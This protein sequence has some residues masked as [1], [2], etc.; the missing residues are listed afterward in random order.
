MRRIKRI[1]SLLAIGPWLL[2]PDASVLAQSV[3]PLMNF[4]GQ[5][6]AVDGSPLTTGD[7][8]LTFQIFDASEG[9][10]LIW[11]PQVLDG[12]GGAGHGP[13]IPVVQGYFNVM[14]GPVD[15]AAR[16]LT[17]A[18]LG[19]TRFL[20][21]KVGTNSPIS[22]RQQILSAPYALNTANAA[23][24]ANV[25]AGGVSTFA[26][27]DGAVTTAKLENGAVTAAKLDPAIG[28]WTRSGNDVFRSLGN[29]GIGTTTPSSPLHVRGGIDTEIAIES[30][31]AAGRRWTLQSSAAVRGHRFEIIDRSAEQNRFTILTNGNVGIG[32]TT[33][34]FPLHIASDQPVMLLHDTGP[35]STQA[36]YIG[37]RNNSFTETAWV[38]YGSPGDPDFTIVNT[39]GDIVLAPLGSGKVGIGT[40]IPNAT[41]S[42]NGTANNVTGAWGVFSDRRLKENIAPMAAGSLDRLLQLK[43]VTYDYNRP[44]LREGYEG[45]HRG[46]IAQEVEQVF[47]EWVSEARDGMKMLTPVGFNA[48]AVEAL[49]ELRCEKDAAVEKLKAE[50]AALKQRLDKLE[51]RIGGW[52]R[53]AK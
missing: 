9:G 51:Q 27:S 28:L 48:L 17:A 53:G 43:G 37:F 10:N 19:A 30:S 25:L 40:P 7:Y 46:W 45:P 12:A 1:L 29:V 8:A 14:L 4:Q 35:N 34:S 50:N 32:T 5:V 6:L 2:L 3:P 21:I 39:R 24:A 47:P 26:L 15:I 22:P 33:P 42:V 16:P 41:L 38:G 44:E 13:K 31:D 36:G 11:G 23:N 18:F 52:S 20:E 49:R